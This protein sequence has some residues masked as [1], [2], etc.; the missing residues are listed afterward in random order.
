[1]SPRNTPR[2]A[3]VYGVDIG[4]NFFHVVG[5]DS[6]GKPVQRVRFRRDTLMKFFERA[7]LAIVGME[8]CA[9]SQ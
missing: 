3:A 1:M 7:A 2:P 6:D 8:S 9:G 4:K 5:L